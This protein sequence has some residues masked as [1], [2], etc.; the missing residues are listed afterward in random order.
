MAFDNVIE[1]NGISKTY[2]T[3]DFKVSA[4]K[5]VSLKIQRGE[6]VAVMGASGSGKSSL[7]NLL[8]CLDRPSGGTY[9][10]EGRDVARLS[11]PEL[12]RVRNRRIGFVFQTFNLLPRL[13]ALRNVE[14][15][16]LFGGKS[17]STAERRASGLLESL[18]VGDLARRKPAEMS[19]GQQQRVAIA[20]ALANDPAIILGDE[21]TGNLDTATSREIMKV[22][23]NL[24][25]EGRTLVVVTHGPE[26][27]RQA[28]RIIR[29]R[30]GVVMETE[31]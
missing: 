20:R 3:G 12:A 8:G 6:F 31:A 24:V 4:V 16:I 23:C 1:M 19:G 26:I 7:L 2:A 28:D 27:G 11:D 25:K 13:S 22:L 17:A 18:G 5:E 21:P 30:D 14:L 15:P 9:R 10:L 29:L